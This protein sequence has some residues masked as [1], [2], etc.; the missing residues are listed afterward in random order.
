MMIIAMAIMAYV[1]YVLSSASYHF[2]IKGDNIEGVMIGIA[3]VLL[4]S[5]CYVMFYWSFFRPAYASL[6]QGTEEKLKNNKTANVQIFFLK[7]LASIFCLME[8]LYCPESAKELKADL[9]RLSR[10]NAHLTHRKHPA[11]NRY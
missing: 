1:L 11:A 7:L 8:L 5:L 2:F 4:F 3:V 9:A 6:F 10:I